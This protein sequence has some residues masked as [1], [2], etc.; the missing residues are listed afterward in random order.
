MPLRTPI[1]DL[2]AG[3]GT[4]A[5]AYS[6]LAGHVLP[7]LLLV[8]RSVCQLALAKRIFTSVDLRR[9]ATLKHATLF[10]YTPPNKY[11]R[12]LSYVLCETT[13][14]HTSA[15]DVVHALVGPGA[16]IID[17]ADIIDAFEKTIDRDRYVCRR[18]MTR[19]ALTSA[20]A[21]ILGKSDVSINALHILPRGLN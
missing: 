18:I 20:T 11:F 15:T 16:I 4:F 17:Y 8:D 10:D 5:L 3:A 6:M 9:K 7:P 1:A 14:Y 2:G 13:W 19:I 12:L 21:T